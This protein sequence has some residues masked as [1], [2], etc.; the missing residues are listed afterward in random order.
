MFALQPV[1]SAL[2]QL[3]D[4]TLEEL[5][6]LRGWTLRRHCP[7]ILDPFPPSCRT[8][9][10][11]TLFRPIRPSYS[12]RSIRIWTTGPRWWLGSPPTTRRTAN[13]KIT[14][15]NGPISSRWTFTA[16]ADCG[17]M[18]SSAQQP[19]LRE[20]AGRLQILFGGR[21][22]PVSRLRVG[23]RVAT[24]KGWFQPF[25]SPRQLANWYDLYDYQ[26]LKELASLVNKWL[27]NKLF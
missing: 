12:T 1:H 26:G 9:Y 25:C 23:V 11:P 13:A 3:D 17:T 6:R 19:P 10:R 18:E 14:S 20:F 7:L 21:K 16:S 4:D 27:T 5:G 24:W 2:F 22:F 15:R 8:S